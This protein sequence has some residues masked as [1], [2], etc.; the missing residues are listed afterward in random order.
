MRVRH[1]TLIAG[2]ALLLPAGLVR[3]ATMPLPGETFDYSGTSTETS[4]SNCCGSG[5]F[6]GSFT[7]GSRVDSSDLWTIVAYTFAPVNL[8]VAHGLLTFDVQFDASKFTLVG[9]IS[10][11]YTGGGGH[12]RLLSASFIDGNNSTDPYSDQDLI[13]PTNSRAGT[14]AYTVSA[15]AVPEP[16]SGWLVFSMVGMAAARRMRGRRRP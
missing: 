16:G 7:L 3:A 6:F 11:P 8:G 14:F 15:A 13:D 12:S 9:G 2:L 10:L 1:F 4:G 5:T